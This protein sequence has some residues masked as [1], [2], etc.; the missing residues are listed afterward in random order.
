MLHVL[1]LCDNVDSMTRAS[2]LFHETIDQV[3]RISKHVQFR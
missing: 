3:N 2:L 1:A